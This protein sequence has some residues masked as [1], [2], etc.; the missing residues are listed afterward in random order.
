[1]TLRP[2]PRS[3]RCTGCGAWLHPGMWGQPSDRALIDPVGLLILGE[4]CGCAARDA[5]AIGKVGE[6]RRFTREHRRR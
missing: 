2:V 6:E 1:M 3:V 5:E 4:S